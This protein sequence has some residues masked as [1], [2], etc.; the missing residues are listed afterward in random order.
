MTNTTEK[1]PLVNVKREKYVKTK[2][3]S[4][5]SSLSN[6]DEVA[7]ALAGLT[8]EEVYEV[9][10]KLIADNDF[11]TRYKKLNPG[12]Q[13]MNIGN[14]LRGF[15]HKDEKNMESFNRIIKPFVKAA[16]DRIKAA[17]KAKADAAKER[18][19]A[20]AAKAK[21]KADAKAAKA[22]AAPKKSAK[23]KAA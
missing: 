21:A 17:E 9:A 2:A 15:C 22:K 5:A 1:E 23:K 19:D 10:N 18:A 13:R 16:A 20:A 8:I 7:T 6:G 4:G 12:M 11:S 3:A 14:R